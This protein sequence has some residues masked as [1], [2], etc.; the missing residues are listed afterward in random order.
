MVDRSAERIYGLR[1]VGR[2]LGL[3]PKRTAQLKRLD[4]L[5][6]DAGYTFRDLMSLRAA[7]ALLDAG[8]SVRQIRQAIT[9]LKLEQ[10]VEWIVP[11][12]HGVS[13]RIVVAGHA[14]Q[15]SRA[16]GVPLSSPLAAAPAEPS[17][18]ASPPPSPR[19]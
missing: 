15:V 1:E 2:I 7:S 3:T 17:S 19:W 8:A 14:S 10:G 11:A 6:N 16:P 5:A 12:D 18:S 13:P 9:S 4:L